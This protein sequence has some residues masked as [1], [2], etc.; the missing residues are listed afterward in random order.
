MLP[1]K[2]KILIAR[3]LD[4]QDYKLMQTYYNSNKEQYTKYVI[5]KYNILSL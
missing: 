2:V 5:T 3:L 1:T 4:I